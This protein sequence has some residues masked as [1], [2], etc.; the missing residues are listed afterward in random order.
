MAGLLAAYLVLLAIHV[1]ACAGGSDSSGYM[2]HARLLGTGHLHS[3][4]RSIPGVRP[5]NDFLYTPLGLK[6]VADGSL[7]PT[8]PVG[9]PLLIL[10]AEPVAGWAHAFDVVVVVHAIAGL[11]LIYGL[12]RGFGLSP[13]WSFGALALLAASPLYL[14]YAVQGMSDLPALVWC[15]AAAAAAWQARG[16]PGWALAAGFAFAFAVLIRPNN[17]LMFAPIAVAWWPSRTD[18]FGWRPAAGRLALFVLGGLP[19]G[20]FFCAH[21]LNAYGSLLTTGYGDAGYLFERRVVRVTLAHYAHWLPILFTPGIWL[22]LG[23]PWAAARSRAAGMLGAWILVYLGFY[24]SYFHTHEAWWYLR[25]LLPA[26]PAFVLGILWMLRWVANAAPASFAAGAAVA[27]LVLAGVAGE[28]YWAK[29][30][31]VLTV[32]HGES[33][34]PDAMAWINAHAPGNAILA[35]M[36]T[37]GAAFFY[38]DRTVVRW[39]ELGPGDFREIADQAARQGRPIY[40]PLFRWETDPALADTMRGHWSA[41]ATIQNITIWRWDGPGAGIQKTP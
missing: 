5:H 19:G 28:A 17:V 14:N 20:V 39:D 21:S 24:V 1:N 13:R 36:Q 3:P 2:N 7:V 22:C 40:A 23:L 9:V 27:C 15:A 6:P 41:V 34:Y 12:A 16:R 11:L 32:G 25:F 4:P 8:Y 38:T 26:A 35:A 37:S 10:A 31:Q 29:K 18:G 30:L 33:A